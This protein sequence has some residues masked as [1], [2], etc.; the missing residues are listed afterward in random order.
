MGAPARLDYR[1]YDPADPAL[2]HETVRQTYESTLDCPELNGARDVADV[3]AGHRGGG[4]F[5]PARWFLALSDGRPVGVLILMESAETA[6]WE[7]S[8]VGVVP[9]ARRRGVGRELMGKAVAE[10][11]A[12]GAS[13]L[14]LSVDARNRPARELYRGLGFE[15]F[16]RREVFLAVW[17]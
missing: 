2:F 4:R 15:L 8:Y 17:K 10:A 1:P 11:R 5:D 6:E 13:A 16:D 3:L 12:A 14:T 9:E 7:T